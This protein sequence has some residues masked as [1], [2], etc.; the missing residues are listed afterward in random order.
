M[1]GGVTLVGERVQVRPAG[2]DA[3]A[4]NATALLKLLR[5]VTVIVDVP[6]APARIWLGE[7]APAAIVKS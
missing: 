6:E 3:E 7:T 4:V 1:L 5:E 2:V